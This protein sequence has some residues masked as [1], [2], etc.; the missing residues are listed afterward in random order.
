VKTTD[1]T[2]MGSLA[3]GYVRRGADGLPR[4]GDRAPWTV[5]NDYLRDAASLKL[6]RVTHPDLEYRA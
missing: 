6:G 4:Q 1:E 2:V 3:S 5:L